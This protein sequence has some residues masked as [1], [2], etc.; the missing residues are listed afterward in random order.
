MISVTIGS[1]TRERH[2]SAVCGYG[3]HLSRAI[4]DGILDL[5]G[6]HLLG[7]DEVRASLMQIKGIGSWSANIYLLMVLLRPD[8]WPS[9]DLA[10]A[11]AAQTVLGRKTRPS[12]EELDVLS[13][14]WTPWRAIAAR[15]LW[16]A[17]LSRRSA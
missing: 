16:H 5:E 15:I 17:Y 3:R 11:V 13:A 8:I 6:L 10:L 2:S 12:S 7:D 1:G 4:L 14:V 9:G